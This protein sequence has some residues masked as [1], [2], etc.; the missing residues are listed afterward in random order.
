MEM[1]R[2]TRMP[3]LQADLYCRDRQDI[4][5]A[6]MPSSISNIRLGRSF[7][8]VL[9]VC[10]ERARTW[11]DRFSLVSDVE[12][13]D[14]I[15]LEIVDMDHSTRCNIRLVLS[16]WM[17]THARLV[18]GMQISVNMTLNK[19]TAKLGKVGAYVGAAINPFSQWR[20]I[21]SLFVTGHVEL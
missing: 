2:V 4:F 21:R 9:S 5:W 19:Y 17:R 20:E 15:K 7:A 13:I 10:T 8:C 12:L 3:P 14:A 11:S 1:P 6:T 18:L 16:I